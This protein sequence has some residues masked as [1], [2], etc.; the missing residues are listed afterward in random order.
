MTALPA[1]KS[2]VVLTTTDRYWAVGFILTYFSA[3]RFYAVSFVLVF[4]SD[5]YNVEEGKFYRVAIRPSL[6]YG[7][8][9][10]PLRKSQE[11]RLEITEMR[12]L[13][14]I[15]GNTKTDHIPNVIFRRLLG[16]ESI[17]KTINLG[18]ELI[19]NKSAFVHN[20]IIT[21]ILHK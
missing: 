3:G 2:D 15:C 10:W 9:C 12:M 16:L 4:C 14:W 8:E 13:R 6:L 20:T 11:R 1:W 5:S 21:E 17:S 19:S 7:S 18:P